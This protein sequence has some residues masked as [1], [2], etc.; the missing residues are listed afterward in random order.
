[1]LFK[2]ET[3]NFSEF[4]SEKIKTQKKIEILGKHQDIFM[5]KHT[6]LLNFFSIEQRDTGEEFQKNL[7]VFLIKFIAILK[8]HHQHQ[9]FYF[10]TI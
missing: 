7:K 2:N 6:A 9:K 8:L 1:M 4:C 10:Q 5:M 3:T